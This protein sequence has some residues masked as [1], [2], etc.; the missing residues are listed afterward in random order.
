ML[1]LPPTSSLAKEKGH[2]PWSHFDGKEIIDA[3]M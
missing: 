1:L 2:I 3:F